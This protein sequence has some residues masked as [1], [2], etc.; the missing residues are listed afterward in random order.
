MKVEKIIPCICTP[1]SKTTDGTSGLPIIGMYFDGEELMLSACC[2][3]CGR[4][5]RYDGKETLEEALEA[6][7]NMQKRLQTKIPASTMRKIRREF[8]PDQDD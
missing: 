6:W 1:E 7:N 5:N 4:G 2:P 3:K 8:E